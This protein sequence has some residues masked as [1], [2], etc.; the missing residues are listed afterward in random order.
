MKFSKVR[1]LLHFVPILTIALTFEKVWWQTSN[2]LVA[3]CETLVSSAKAC[4]YFS[5]RSP[6]VTM[7]LAV[8]SV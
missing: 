4:L 2:R 6:L 8:V 5:E 1:F 3:A 7:Q